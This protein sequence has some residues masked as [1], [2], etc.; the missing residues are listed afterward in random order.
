[1]LC[2]YPQ[3]FNPVQN[4][5]VEQLFG[6]VEQTLNTHTHTVSALF[7]S[8][9]FAKFECLFHLSQNHTL[10]SAAELLVTAAPLRFL[11]VTTIYWYPLCSEKFVV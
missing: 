11:L 4:P 3:I 9:Y 1:M 7:F 8:L 2:I 5:I 10:V 6:K